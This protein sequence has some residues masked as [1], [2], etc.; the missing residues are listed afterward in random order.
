[1][2]AGTLSLTIAQSIA[3]RVLYG[4]GHIRL[5]ARVALL[6][7]IA[8][9]LLS[10]A[11]V[12]PL[13]IAGVAW[14]TAIPHTAACVFAVVHAGQLIG[15]RP[16]DYL[17]AWSRPVITAAVPLSIWLM[18]RSPTT[19]AEF[20]ATGL[21]GIAPYAAIVLAAERRSSM[22]LAGRRF[23]NVVRQAFQSAPR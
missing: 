2:L 7:G 16:A 17:R 13:G 19:Y 21:L 18:Q 6:E 12:V 14:G 1:V 23:G 20:V 4:V 10:I 11:L 9:L 8:N 15:V 22:M 3:A 5:L